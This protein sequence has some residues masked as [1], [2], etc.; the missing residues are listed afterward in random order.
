MNFQEAIPFLEKNHN[1]VGGTKR[2]DGDIHSSIVVSGVFRNKAAFVS[3]YPKSQKVR[4]LKRNPHCPVLPVT[5]NWRE[6]VVVEGKAE[7]MDY[8]NTDAKIL[9]PL[10]R[11]VYMACSDTEHPDW[12][13]YDEAMVNQKAV[14]VLVNPEKIYGLLRH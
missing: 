1:G 5:P 7:L 12:D 9:K 2:L 8:G 10:L 11:E 3:V 4:N 14:I 6:Y 13:E